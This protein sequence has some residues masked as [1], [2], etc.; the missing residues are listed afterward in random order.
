[1]KLNP[2]ANLLLLGTLLTLTA[3]GCKKN[4]G[5]ITNIPGHKANMG[6]IG[7]APLNTAPIAPL[8]NP[9]GIPAA[10]MENFEGR[11]EDRGPLAAATVYF[12]YDSSVVKSSQVSKLQDVAT[13]LKNNPADALLIEGHCDERGTEEY[14]RALGEKR[15]QALREHLSSKLGVDAGNIRTISYGK[16]RPADAGHNDAAW[17]KNRRGEFVVLLPKPRS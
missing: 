11:P 7:G 2:F 5:Y 1:M 12:D 3:V 10:G 14:N 17:A 6:D 13:F 16:D 8:D 9:N 4:P 15:A